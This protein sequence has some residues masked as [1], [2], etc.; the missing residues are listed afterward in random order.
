MEDESLE[1]KIENEMIRSMESENEVMVMV[2]EGEVGG[3]GRNVMKLIEKE[4]IMDRGLKVREMKI[5]DIY[6]ENGKKDEMYEEEGIESKGIV[7]KVFEEIN[8]DE[9]GNEE[10]KKKF[11][12]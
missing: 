3:F 6:K 7:R 12:E 5:K 8:R 10:M 1:K 11:S 9:M 4:G 2:E